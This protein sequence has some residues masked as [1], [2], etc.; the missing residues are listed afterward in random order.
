MAKT[1]LRN[2]AGKLLFEDPG[3]L[4]HLEEEPQPPEPIACPSD[5]SGC[6]D[7]LTLVISGFDS[8]QCFDG[9]T[10]C[11]DFNGSGPITRSGCQWSG[12]PGGGLWN[13]YC[14]GETWFLEQTVIGSCKI[15]FSKP[16][17][18]GC[19][20]TGAY[21]FVDEGNICTGGTATVSIP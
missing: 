3:D 1:L 14:T 2:G 15:L 16:N 17:I 12:S 9:P 4:L 10:L 21:E 13:L 11:S 7:T 5:C 6:P 20:P 18:D 8:S 19:P